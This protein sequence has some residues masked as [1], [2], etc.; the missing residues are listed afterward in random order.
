MKADESER[1]EVKKLVYLGMP[2]GGDKS[3]LDA[4]ESLVATLCKCFDAL[5]WAPWVPLCRY[6]PNSGESLE[7][8][9]ILD[10]NAIDNS[11][12]VLLVG[13]RISPG[14][15]KEV[16]FAAKHGVPVAFAVDGDPSAVDI[17]GALKAHGIK[18][19]A[20]AQSHGKAATF[21]DPTGGVPEGA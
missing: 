5:F 7:V 20:C 11:D 9:M 14:M 8:G 13:P 10:E 18:R 21:Q 16:E 12:L 1:A 15:A 6:W 17:D 3:N 2:Y 4:A 19:R